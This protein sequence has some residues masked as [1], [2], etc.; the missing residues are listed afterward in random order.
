MWISAVIILQ[1]ETLS[2]RAGHEIPR[3]ASIAYRQSSWHRLLL[4]LQT[5]FDPKR[6][7]SKMRF[8]AFQVLILFFTATE[9]TISGKSLL[10]REII[11]TFLSVF[12]GL[13]FV[14]RGKLTADSTSFS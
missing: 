14:L 8:A 13:G 7:L 4:P 5:R 2:V 9:E 12:K 1:S 10:R 11:H 3:L 6:D